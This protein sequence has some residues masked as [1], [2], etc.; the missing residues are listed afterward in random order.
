[1]S[2]TF[3]ALLKAEKEYRLNLK[4]RPPVTAEAIKKGNG[5]ISCDGFL[6]LRQSLLCAADQIRPRLLAFSAS[7]RREGS[8]TVLVN[9]AWTLAAGDERVIAV[10]G[11]LQNPVL[12]QLFGVP[13]EDGL[14]EVLHHG[15]DVR[16]VLKPTAFENLK[17]LTA[18][19]GDLTGLGARELKGINFLLEQMRSMAEWMLFDSPAINASGDALAI[20]S[21]VDGV[22]LVV[23]S[24]KTR[25]EVAQSAVRRLEAARAKVLGVVLN[26]RKMPIPEWIYKRL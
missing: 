22:V 20:A 14:I 6:D 17:V 18:G 4:E 8:S 10:D 26:R 5:A 16:E 2:R 3:D 23:L 21:K 1:M 11:N 19:R 9:F 25:R 13:K 12:H 24:D 15:R 7:A